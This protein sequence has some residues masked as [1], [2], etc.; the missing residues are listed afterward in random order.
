MVLSLR[1]QDVRQACPLMAQIDAD[2][3]LQTM[4]SLFHPSLRL[5][6]Q[7]I[8]LQYNAGEPLV[9]QPRQPQNHSRTC[10]KTPF[11]P[12]LPDVYLVVSA[13]E[14]APHISQE[15]PRDCCRIPLRSVLADDWVFLCQGAPS[16]L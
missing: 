7:A 12:G 16:R 10:W 5:T 3:T 1:L 2:T 4:L 15:Y 14:A 9:K 6:S 8:K 13:C 11:Y